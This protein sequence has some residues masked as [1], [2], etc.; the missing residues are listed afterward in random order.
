[1]DVELFQMI[2]DA[3]GFDQAV[4]PLRDAQIVID[5]VKVFSFFLFALF[6]FFS[7]LSLFFLFSVS[8]L[9]PLQVAVSMRKARVYWSLAL[10]DNSEESFRKGM[11][12]ARNALKQYGSALRYATQQRIQMKKSPFPLSLSPFPF[13]FLSPSSSPSSL[14]FLSPRA[15]ELD[16]IYAEMKNPILVDHLNKSMKVIDHVLSK[17]QQKEAEDEE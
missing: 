6:S 1:M 12:R 15:P 11:K 3:L 2:N 16:F 10:E 13:P 14:T 8:F 9:N 7:F 17:H 4:Q 5:D